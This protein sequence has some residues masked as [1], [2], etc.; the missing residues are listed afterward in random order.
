MS[1][2]WAARQFPFT[3]G[4]R[5]STR[6]AK[7]HRKLLDQGVTFL[8]DPADRPY[9]V[10]AVLRDNTGNWLVLVET[11]KFDPADLG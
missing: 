4:F 3:A 9:G 5:A 6:P 11:E 10:A 1:G 2:R 7:T 8:Q